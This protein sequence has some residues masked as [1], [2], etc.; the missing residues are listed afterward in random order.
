MMVAVRMLPVVGLRQAVEAIAVAIALVWNSKELSD[1]FVVA[2]TIVDSVVGLQCGRERERERNQSFEF[3]LGVC[4][5]ERMFER[6]VESE[7][8]FTAVKLL[9]SLILMS[10]LPCPTNISM[11]L[12]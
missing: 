6:A 10:A 9:L 8:T 1:Y 2:V 5:S 4:E 12:V 3:E 11:H 7:D